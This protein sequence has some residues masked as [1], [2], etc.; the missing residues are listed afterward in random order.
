MNLHRGLIIISSRFQAAIV[1][2]KVNYQAKIG[3]A[4]RNSFIF[5]IHRVKEHRPRIHTAL[6]ADKKRLFVETIERKADY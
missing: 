2:L 4:D 6:L 3:K 1:C 5:F